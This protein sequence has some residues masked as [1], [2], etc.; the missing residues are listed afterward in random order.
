MPNSHS[1]VLWSRVAP[2]GSLSL[3]LHSPGFL[4]ALEIGLIVSIS[5]GTGTAHSLLRFGSAGDISEYAAGGLLVA[6]LYAAVLNSK[7]LYEPAQILGSDAGAANL[8]AWWAGVFAIAA[9]IAFALKAGSEFSRGGVLSFFVVGAFGAIA[10]RKAASKWFRRQ[11]TAGALS[12]LKAVLLYDADQVKDGEAL[13]AL[14]RCGYRIT[15]AFG[16]SEHHP[17][18]AC[19]EL[20]SYTRANRVDEVVVAVGWGAPDRIEAIRKELRVLPLAVRLMPDRQ[21][22]PLLSYR[23]EHLG[24]TVLFEL[25]RAPFSRTQRVVK[26]AV[27]VALASAALVLFAPLMAIVAA[28]VPLGS[29]GPV[30]FRQ[31]RSGF[32]GER[33]AIWKF[34]TMSVAE[35]GHMIRQATANDPRVTRLGKLLRR[36]SIDELPQLFNVLRGE[37][38]LVGPRPHAEAHDTEFD[39]TVADYALRNHVK[40]GITGWAQVNGHRGETPD[41]ASVRRRVEHDLWYI[42]NWTLVLEFRILLKTAHAVIKGTNAH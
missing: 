12:G 19:R 29:P 5:V 8:F 18:E 41:T 1:T 2:Q 16:I 30:F 40:P 10:T 27:D 33:F 31:R 15:S 17:G 24:S 38:S 13:A 20:I 9:V 28:L 34:R 7:G 35:N 3:S 6:L 32:N 11:A 21:L 14:R 39:R 42:D 22:Q 4:A 26:R 25:A 23:S 37:M 36:T